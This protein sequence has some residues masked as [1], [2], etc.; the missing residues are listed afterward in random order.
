MSRNRNRWEETRITKRGQNAANLLVEPIEEWLDA[1]WTPDVFP[2]ELSI[3]AKEVVE[4]I[5]LELGLYRKHAERQRQ[6]GEKS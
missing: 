4:T 5:A 1:V 6:L 2:G 3:V